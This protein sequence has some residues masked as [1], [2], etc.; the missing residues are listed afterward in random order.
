MTPLSTSEKCFP[1]PGGRKNKLLALPAKNQ[2]A[3]EL[4]KRERGEEK[5]SSAC[6]NNSIS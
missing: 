6:Q 1:A 2:G 5:L 4:L 3:K